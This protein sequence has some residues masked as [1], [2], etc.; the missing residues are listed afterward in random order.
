M[1]TAQTQDKKLQQI[2]ADCP[3]MKQVILDKYLK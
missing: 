2:I 1:Y 3:G